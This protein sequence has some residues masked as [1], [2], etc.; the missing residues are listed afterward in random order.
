[1]PDHRRNKYDVIVVGAGPAGCAASL[2]ASIEG[3]A[4]LLIEK[5]TEEEMLMYDRTSFEALQNLTQKEDALELISRTGFDLEPAYPYN[6]G[7]VHGPSGDT[8]SFHLKRLHGHFMRRHGKGSMDHQMLER[9]Q[10]EGIEVMTGTRVNTVQTDGTVR[11]TRGRVP[12]RLRAGV[13]IGADGRSTNA[14]LGV[15][16]PLGK[17]D[18]ALGLGYHFKGPHGFDPGTAECWL[19][20]RVCPGEYAYVLASRDEA[21]VVTT[22]R[23]HLMPNGLGPRTYLDRFLALPSIRE[24]L[25]GT[26]RIGTVLGSIPVR[27]GGPMGMGKVLLVGEAAR[28]TDPMLGFGIRNAIVSGHL[29]GISSAAEDPLGTYRGLME[30]HILNDLRKRMAVRQRMLDRVSDHVLDG[31]I[32]SLSSIT[33]TFDPDLFIRPGGVLRMVG[34]F[35]R[36]LPKG[37]GVVNAVRYLTPFAVANYSL[38]SHAPAL[39]IHGLGK[40]EISSVRS[41]DDSI[42]VTSGTGCSC[43]APIRAP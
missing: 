11:I 4:V 5:R 14:G 35:I 18:I 6:G 36:S 28:T 19:G 16:D 22:L 8:F 25:E 34:E 32:G 27:S 20:S 7:L 43:S 1:M 10:R 31:L 17:D 13:V 26:D 29:A 38:I 41:K 40:G 3:L 2:S 9:V 12:Y 37:R 42:W 21:T 15:T 33:R 24:R 30:A 39:P 23:P